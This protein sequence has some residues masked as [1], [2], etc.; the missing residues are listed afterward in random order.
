[1]TPITQQPHALILINTFTVQPEKQQALINLLN[2]ATTEVMKHLP[3]FMSAYI[4][5]SLDGT[6][7]A[8]YAKWRSLEDFQAMFN[9]PQAQEHMQ[10]ALKICDSFEPLL[11]SLET[12]HEAEQ[13]SCQ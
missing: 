3:G 7:V 4:H 13:N 6:K 9:D 1:M 12:C 10:E 2:R 11:Y 5:R 8:N